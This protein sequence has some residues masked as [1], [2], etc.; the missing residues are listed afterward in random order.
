MDQRSRVPERSPEKIKLPEGI[1]AYNEL[2]ETL[3]FLDGKDYV[4]KPVEKHQ[5]VFWE[6]L[7]NTTD[8]SSVAVKTNKGTF[9]IRLHKN[10]APYAVSNLLNL[11]E[12]K[13][14]QQKI[15][16][17][18]EPNFVIQTGCPRGD[19][20]GSLDFTIP[21]E[22]SSGNYNTSGLVGMAS[23]GNHTECSQWFVTHSSAPHLDGNYTIFGHITEGMEVVNG[24]DVG[25][26]IIEIIFIK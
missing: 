7:N 11:I 20:N 14:Y 25:D 26:K 13:Y 15:I 17:R 1:E 10:L 9:R 5:P 19:G 18:V 24:L 21:S 22:L 4:R 12:K 8:S 23:A 2:D 16:H 3:H 6:L